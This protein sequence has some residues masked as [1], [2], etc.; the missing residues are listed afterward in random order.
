[1]ADIFRSFNV[2]PPGM[3]EGTRTTSTR[4]SQGERDAEKII[5]IV[6][7]RTFEP[8]SLAYLLASHDPRLAKPLFDLAVAIINAYADKNVT[9]T[10]G[11]E[12]YN[13]SDASRF[14]LEQIIAKMGRP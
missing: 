9:G 5:N 10:E 12:E 11:D 3:Y 4:R 8:H 14:V 2:H 1:M 13:V 6:N 7:V